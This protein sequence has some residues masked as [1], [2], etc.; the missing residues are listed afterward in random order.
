MKLSKSLPSS[1]QQVAETVSGRKRI[2]V[3]EGVLH[4]N[5]L[6]KTIE[7]IDAQR[8]ALISLHQHIRNRIS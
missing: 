4:L 1:S 8:D 7:Q 3:S 5:E 2:S 6:N